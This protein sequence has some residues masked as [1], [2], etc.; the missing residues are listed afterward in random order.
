[1]SKTVDE[2]KRGYAPV[3]A[4]LYPELCVIFQK[5]GY[6]LAVHGSMRRDFDLVAIPWASEVST[7]EVV[8]DEIKRVFA[9]T[10]MG[11]ATV[12]NHGRIA[13]TLAI[14]FGACAMDLSFTPEARHD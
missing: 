7:H 1:M 10:S 6:A 9:T 14:G 13:Y 8:L 4:A 5:H 12:K 11:G 3:Y 2:I